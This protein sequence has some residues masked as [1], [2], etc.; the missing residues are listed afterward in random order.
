MQADSVGRRWRAACRGR[1]VQ[2]HEHGIQE[3]GLWGPFAPLRA[4]KRACRASPEQGAGG[5]PAPG[6][7][8]QVSTS[9]SGLI[10]VGSAQYYGIVGNGM[11][12]TVAPSHSGLQPLWSAMVP[13][14]VYEVA[15]LQN[16]GETQ[17][18]S[19]AADGKVRLHDRRLADG[20]PCMEWKAHSIESVSVDCAPLRG[21]CLAR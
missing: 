6:S 19:A 2:R 7:L 9:G 10:A 3:A 1:H 18:A 13:A 11:L 17:V 8:A 16:A 12:H 14:G 21:G 20:L 15:W 4:P 5:N